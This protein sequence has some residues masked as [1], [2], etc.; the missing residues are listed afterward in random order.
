MFTRAR[1]VLATWFT[2][3]FVITLVAVGASAYLLIRRDIDKEIDG[4]LENTRIEL[5]RPANSPARRQ[6]DNRT[7]RDVLAPAGLGAGYFDGPDFD[8]DKL[9]PGIPA[10]VFIVY[11]DGEGTIYANPRSVD[12]D[13][14]DFAK[15]CDAASGT[16]EVAD[17]AAGG[18]HYRF[19]SE[20]IANS[21]AWIH[22]GRSLEARDRQLKTLST[23]FLVGG[24]GGVLAS[25]MG[26]VWLAGIALR[27]IRKSYERQQRFVSDASHEL[28]T[29]L[30]VL[31]ANGELLQ[32]H[33]N[34]SIANNID[35]VDAITAEAEA[36]T[37]L[38]DDLLLLARADEGE[39]TI[40]REPV[41]LGAVAE[42]L[43]RDMEALAT[44]H[45]IT[46][47][48]DAQPVQVE[49]DRHRLR[50]LG[51]IL[52]DNAIKYTEPGGR[53]ELHCI[54][55]GKWVE[56]S[57][58][59]TGPGIPGHLQSKIFDRFVRADAARTRATGGAGLGLAIAKWIAEAHGGR[60]AVESEPGAGTK[61]TVR[62]PALA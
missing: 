24:F 52:L 8:G 12:V 58:T 33:A 46:L 60:I 9:P 2:L 35:Q 47:R 27:P 3:A 10:D 18:S 51:A 57:V 59:D 11:T 13:D 25:A 44:E 32:R 6:A 16:H 54:Q 7:S 55:S 23:V 38:V 29:P 56:F 49:G 45:H 15:L 48:V 36:M 62:L 37:K 4:S 43:G 20:E 31:R 53:V 30:A 34:D 50:Q 21:D 19:I 17:V 40:A 61:F 26:G 42:E 1:L 41:S 39:A 22:I 14:V 5:M 28:R